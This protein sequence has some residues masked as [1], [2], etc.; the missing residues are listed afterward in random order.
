MA[1]AQSSK[2]LWRVAGIAALGACVAFMA[3]RG[4]PDLLA[5]LGAVAR[6]WITGG[7]AG[8]LWCTAAIGLGLWIIGAA[9]P[10]KDRSQAG[11]HLS[12]DQ[13]ALAGCAGAAIM[14]FLAHGLGVLG[15]LSGTFGMVLSWAVVMVGVLNL[16]KAVRRHAARVIERQ[17]V[18]TVSWVPRLVSL[19]CIPTLGVLIVSVCVPTGTLWE[20]EARGYDSLSYHLGLPKEWAAVGRL[21]PL[22]HNAYSWLPS[23]VEAAYLQLAAMLGGAGTDG[24]WITA[25]NGLHAGML[26]MT[27]LVIVALARAVARRAEVD[28]RTAGWFGGACVLVVPWCVV[29]GSLSYNEMGMLL[30]TAGACLVCATETDRAGTRGVLAGFLLGTATACKPTAAF[31]GGPLVLMAL[32]AWTPRRVWWRMLFGAFIGGVAAS[33][34]WLVRNWLACGNP[35]FPSLSSQF[36]TGPWDAG[37]IERWN[38]AHHVRGGILDAA[39]RLL[40]DRGVMHQ[41]WSVFFALVAVA[42]V[43]AVT[44]PI[45]RRPTWP[46]VLGL[47]AQLLA[48]MTIGHH[49]PRFLMPCVVTG[50][51]LMGVCAGIASCAT[52]RRV[53]RV[54]IA[55]ATLGVAWMSIDTARIYMRENDGAPARALIGGAPAITGAVLGSDDDLSRT[56]PEELVRALEDAGNPIA[57]T[58]RLIGLDA[59]RRAAAK[60]PAPLVYLLGDATPTYFTVPVLWNT[61]W[62]RW[63]LEEARAAAPNDPGSWASALRDRGVTH[64]LINLS[65]IERLRGSG[66]S[67]PEMT[68]ET[69]QRFA[70]RL[71]VDSRWPPIGVALYSLN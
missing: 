49:Q 20:S 34:P 61:V 30:G 33:V 51:V 69:A 36:G 21:W 58:N 60:Q 22:E 12:M 44:Q 17:T 25:C 29:T 39:V 47:I 2:V 55:V 3:T 65:E 71:R 54:G 41:Q 38:A 40:S 28:D 62:D 11:A 6:G 52:S 18:I 8:L 56:D 59:R 10:E 67:P 23:Y 66:Y 45:L 57:A 31:M 32:L 13:L 24:R 70:A 48:W 15:L 53:S 16:A 63:P 43:V 50:A 19:A 26:G 14:L 5:A 27:A 4:E 46:I 64:V 42:V 7:F 1:A 35:V 9:L 68:V 37:Q